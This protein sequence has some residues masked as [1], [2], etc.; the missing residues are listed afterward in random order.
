MRMSK[1]P[2][3]RG[4]TYVKIASLSSHILVCPWLSLLGCTS[5][6]SFMI[7]ARCAKNLTWGFEHAQI[8]DAT[9][10]M[11]RLLASVQIYWWRSRASPFT[12]RS[13]PSLLCR[14]PRWSYLVA[15]IGHTKPLLQAQLNGLQLLRSTDTSHGYRPY[16]QGKLPDLGWAAELN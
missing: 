9:Y 4:Y 13:L 16:R 7:V 6:N 15:W 1:Y 10:A 14:A 12:S 2:A 11:A 5:T 8:R 3:G